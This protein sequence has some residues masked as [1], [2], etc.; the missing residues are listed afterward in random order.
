MYM[1]VPRGMTP[2]STATAPLRTVVRVAPVP[3]PPALAAVYHV[4]QTVRVRAHCGS[5]SGAAAG[6]AAGVAT[7]AA[8][9]ASTTGAG[10]GGTAA[11]GGGG[12]AAPGRRS[13]IPSMTLSADVMPL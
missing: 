7:G 4:A 9:A 1:R 11:G 3:T 8:T 12:G 2:G 6:V 5:P 13:A 10:G